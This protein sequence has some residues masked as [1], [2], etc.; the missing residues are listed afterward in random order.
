MKKETSYIDDYEL[1]EDP[2]T[3]DSLDMKI[4]TM[5][6]TKRAMQNLDAIEKSINY[7]KE[8]KED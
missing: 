5:R 4:H 2:Q 7:E 3:W 8:H 6:V 1:P